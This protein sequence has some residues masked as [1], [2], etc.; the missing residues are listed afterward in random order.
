MDACL[1]ID[2]LDKPSLGWASTRTGPM[3]VL[4]ALS[5]S[6]REVKMKFQN[7]EISEIWLLEM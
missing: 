3:F 6:H 4:F 5:F 1:A 2:Q 7:F